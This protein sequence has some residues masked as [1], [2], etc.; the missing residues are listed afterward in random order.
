MAV[1]AIYLAAALSA[2]RHDAST[3]QAA[4]A[5]RSRPPP[6]GR[7]ARRH[8]ESRLPDPERDRSRGLH[9]GRRCGARRRRQG[10]H[11]PLV[12]IQGHAGHRG[13]PGG[14]HAATGAAPRRA[15]GHRGPA[16]TG[17]SRG[18][19]LPRPRRA[20]AARTDRAGSGRQRDQP[21][22]AHRLRRAAPA[23]RHAPAGAGGRQRRAADADTDIAVLADALWGPI[24]HRLLVSHSPID[25]GFIE[26][27]LDLVL[28]GATRARSQPALRAC[29]YSSAKEG[30]QS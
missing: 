2:L 29:A 28:G 18:Q 21:P 22:A 1:P 23:G 20:A 9:G 11:L 14:A 25:R 12:E 13:V 8:P 24:L 19:H 30:S 4:Q 6:F 3:A 15:L 17:A 5:P 27:L 26:K 10:H 7:L 16:R